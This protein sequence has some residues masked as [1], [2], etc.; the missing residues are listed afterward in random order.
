MTTLQHGSNTFASM[1][2]KVHGEQTFRSLCLITTADFE[3]V[4]KRPTFPTNSGTNSMKLFW[5][6]FDGALKWAGNS[7]RLVRA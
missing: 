7:S 4:I 5:P 2:G 3:A 6:S 1:C